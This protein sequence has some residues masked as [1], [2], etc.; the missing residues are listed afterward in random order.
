MIITIGDRINKKRLE[1]GMTLE[2]LGKRL[3]LAKWQFTSTSLRL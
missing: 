2:E 1:K 3:A